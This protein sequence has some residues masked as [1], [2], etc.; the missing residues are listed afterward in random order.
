M[1]LLTL[2]SSL[3]GFFWG[4]IMIYL[5]L[6]AGIYFSVL[7]KFPQV[8]LIKDMVKHLFGSKSSAEGV[9]SFQGFAMALGGRVGTGNITGVAS[10]IFF[11]GPGAVF[12]M[13]AIAFLGAGSAYIEAALAQ[14]WK[15]EIHGEY[16]GGPAYYIEK[17]LGSRGLG[18]AFAILT[19]V[20]CGILLPGIQSNSFATAATVAFGIDPL[21]IAVLYAGLL[22]YIVFGGGKRIAKVAGMIVPFMAIAYMALAFIILIINFDKIPYVF[23]LIFSS[24]F[25]MNAAY[26]AVFGLA[27]SWGVKR[28]IFSNEAGQ[29]T[30]A[31]A[32][33]A[34]EVSHPA[35]QGLVQAFSVYV[36][37]L[38]VCT[39]T[40]IMILSTNTF[41]VANPAGGFLTEFVPG[42]EKGNF[43]Q[44][45]VDAF[46]PGIGGGFVAIALGFFTFTTVL[47]YA[48][49]TDS[50]VGYLF[51]NNSN[52]SGYKMAIT[53]S[54]IGIVLMVFIS[55]IMSADVVWNF[56]SAGVGAMAWF[57]VIVI[58]LL[59]KPGIAT[60]KDYEAQKKLGVDPVF[61]P[62]RCGIK[63]AE[64]WH[65]IVARSY[66][67]EL[68][69]L[70]DKDKKMA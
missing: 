39:A 4:K 19:L 15:Q 54:R 5:C 10:A 43:T 14:V 11:G 2:S 70:K 55:T 63:G 23:G 21:I 6:A 57:N 56:G 12:W 68:A 61:V 30:G 47:A 32:A 25:N 24:A 31:Q 64:L 34:A 17:G 59:T 22:G 65:K 36:D 13:W 7:M 38:L 58:I 42:L 69:A 60:L 51:R 18:M 67:K 29:G 3:D 33:G 28:G 26:G 16:R 50:N 20:S 52:G 44:T 27:I 40:A 41:N 9:S 62:E 35:K 8:R 37:T 53:A 66:S 49:Y 48:F 45:A 1:D 46:I